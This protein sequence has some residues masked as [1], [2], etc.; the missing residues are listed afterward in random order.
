MIRNR[1]AGYLSYSGFGIS[2]FSDADFEALH[3]AS[4]EVLQDVGIGIESKD[5]R[6]IYRINGALVDPETKI[7]KIPP[8]MVEEALRSV[9]SRIKFA[10][11]DPAKDVVLEAGRVNFS[12]FGSA[13]MVDDPYTGENRKS[14]K[15]DIVNATI[16]QDYLDQLDVTV[17]TMICRDQNPKTNMLHSFEAIVNNTTKCM[18]TAPADKRSAQVLLEMAG[19]VVGGTQNLRERP[20][21]FGCGLPIS[22]LFLC[23]G[24]CD[25]LIEYAKLEVPF[26]LLSMVNSGATSPITLGGSLVVLNAELLAGI[27]LSQL[28]KKGAPFI[29]GSSACNMNM[30]YGTASVGSPEA[31]LLNAAV[32]K[33]ARYYNI[34]SWVSGG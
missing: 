8:Y 31:A 23:E 15:A 16:V 7:V 30:R 24:V 28:V 12:A 22:P 34:P 18:Y 33:I 29:Y 27:V 2:M 10:G 32:V 19:T 11:R 17:E 5:A 6:D 20:I 14:T 25:S 26:L 4:L 9:P 1:S 21:V 13:V 3:L